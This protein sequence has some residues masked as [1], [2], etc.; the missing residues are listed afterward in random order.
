MRKIEVKK[1]LQEAIERK[2]IVKAR[3]VIKRGATSPPA[4]LQ[5]ERG[6]VVLNI[7]QKVALVVDNL[8]PGLKQGEI[9]FYLGRKEALE[10]EYTCKKKD[11]YIERAKLSNKARERWKAGAEKEELK[12]YYD[13]IQDKTEEL[14][15]LSNLIEHIQKF[16]ELPGDG[17]KA[18]SENI[19]VMKDRKRQLI[20][21]RDKLRRNLRPNA[22]QP[23]N[24]AR[25]SHWEQ[26][27]ALL[28]A[29][30]D[31]LKEKINRLNYDTRD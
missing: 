30:Y 15:K 12:D 4:P 21:Q 11:V 29:E 23:L 7:Q 24:S 18:P 5:K 19:L 16:G 1:V 6:E 2:K 27:L 31:D 22:K 26:T 13:H 9:D 3:P 20:N 8:P 10:L 28:D 25:K 14:A 17:G